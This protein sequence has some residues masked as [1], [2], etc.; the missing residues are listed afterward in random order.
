MSS[1]NVPQIF[2]PKRK[3]FARLRS[4][5]SELFE[6]RTYHFDAWMIDDIAERIEFVRHVP[7]YALLDGR[8]SSSRFVHQ[9]GV[10][11]AFQHNFDVDLDQPL[12]VRP[13]SFDTVISVGTLDTVN[14]LPGALIQIRE[15]LMPGG[16]AIASFVGGTSLPKLRTA[17]LAA[18][19]DRPAARLHPMIDT[20]ACPDLLQRAGWKSPVVD[21]H[22]I[23][24]RYPDLQSLAIDLRSHGW[25]NTLRS[26]P[27]AL[28]KAAKKRAERAF[29]DQADH[30]GLISE[31]FEIITLTGWRE[32]ELP[33][34]S[35]RPV[36][37]PIVR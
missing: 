10:Q 22:T 24:A 2:S 5:L 19:E 8:G 11:P 34:P 27:P 21:S 9:L 18:D 29:R 7:A 4:S 32:G 16:L 1:S 33:S 12:A 35:E 15:L 36:P 20:R 28:S 23:T 30:D 17:L 25:T 26:V 37:Q 6:Y 14:D 13:A 31:T 3:A